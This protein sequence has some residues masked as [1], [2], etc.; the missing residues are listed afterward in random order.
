MRRTSLLALLLVP[1]LAAA[2][3]LLATTAAVRAQPADNLSA[4][5]TL[6]NTAR[7]PGTVDTI[8]PVNSGGKGV[9]CVFNRT[10]EVGAPST[11]IS[12]QVE[13]ATSGSWQTLGSAAAVTGATGSAA[14]LIYPGAV[15]TSVPSGLSVAGL[16][17]SRIW[18]LR[19]VITGATSD[20]GSASCDLLN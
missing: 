3:A 8:A 10:A 4:V 13:D 14:L 7:V 18:R 2:L 15:A 16:K 5:V 1:A 19:Q 9:Y 20:T 11:V 17:V 6:T 12:V